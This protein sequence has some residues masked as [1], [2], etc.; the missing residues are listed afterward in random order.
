RRIVT[1]IGAITRP[2]GRRGSP[3]LM[4]ARCRWC[5][6]LAHARSGRCAIGTRRWAARRR[7]ARGH[8]VQITGNPIARHGH[9]AG[10]LH[11]VRHGATLRG[12]EIRRNRGSDLLV[13]ASARIEI[14]AIAIARDRLVVIAG[15]IGSDRFVI[16]LSLVRGHRLVK[17]TLDV[18]RRAHRRTAG[19]R[20][21]TAR[22]RRRTT[23]SWL[24]AA[25]AG[26]PDAGQNRVLRAAAADLEDVVPGG[27]GRRRADR[28][29][30]QRAQPDSDPIGFHGTISFVK[31]DWTLAVAQS[32]DRATGL[33]HRSP[34]Y[35]ALERRSVCL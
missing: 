10:S 28:E 2:T 25:V 26:R 8:R 16:G 11:V 29:Q 35:D 31:S 19:H 6:L 33:D 30:R 1:I 21:G 27:F 24:A 4:N 20:G 7:G 3:L 12:E 5:G 34:A 9:A 32:P 14:A 17:R 18:L 15:A 23:G 22:C 13:A